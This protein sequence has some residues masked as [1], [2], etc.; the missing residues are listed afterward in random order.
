ATDPRATGAAGYDWATGAAPRTT[1]AADDTTTASVQPPSNCLTPLH[2]PLAAP[3]T[4]LTRHTLAP[5]CQLPHTH[6]LAPLH[7]LPH[8][9]PPRRQLQQWETEEE[10]EQGIPHTRHPLLATPKP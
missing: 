1:G 9:H 7:R 6:P 4:L 8:T 3:L 10:E 5:R 2:T